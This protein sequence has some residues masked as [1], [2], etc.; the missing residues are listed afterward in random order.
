MRNV[1]KVLIVDDDKSS[2]TL[3]S[4]VVKRLGFK[5]IIAMK[6][7]D[8]LNVAKLQ[9][10]HAAIIDVLLPKIGGVD[11]ALEFRKTKFAENPIIF[12]SGVF[13]DKNFAT[14]SIRKTG[15]LEFLFKPFNAEELQTAL[16]NA[17]ASQMVTE[18]MTAQS[19]LVRRLDSTRDKA[20]AIEHLEQVR[21]LEFP[22]VLSI[23][24][25]AGLSGHL[26]IVND[27]GEI[28]GVT[29]SKGTIAEVD[30]TES[31][32]TGVLALIKNGFM[33]QEDFDAFQTEASKK[34]P[35]DRLVQ[36]GLVSPHA[37]AVAK[38]EQ[39]LHDFKSICASQTMQVNFVPQE[40]SETPPKHA[41]KMK[42]LLRIMAS[43]MDEFFPASYLAEFY[44]VVKA[45]PMHLARTPDQV[46]PIWES[47][48]FSPLTALRQAVEEGGTLETV[49][50]AHPKMIAQ[51][52]QCLH[53][54][55]LSRNVVFDD[56]QRTKSLNTMLERYQQLL[57]QISGKTPDKVFEYFGGGERPAPSA[58][59]R[60]WDQYQKSNSPDQLPKDATQELRD[61][62]QRCYDIFEGAKDVMADEQKRAALFESL[63]VEGHA[64]HK[65]SNEMAAQALE[66]LRKGQ[67]E[68]AI[69]IC[70]EAMAV[71]ST[72]LTFLIQTW[73]QVKGGVVTQKPQL[74]EL[75][76]KLDGMAPDDRKSTYWYMTMGLL[77]KA[78]LDVS[79]ISM[80]EKVI[81]MDSTFMEARR[82]LNSISQTNTR[83]VDILNGDISAV[84]SQLFRTKA[85]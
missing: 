11:L 62:C 33:T 58:V 76:K 18:K 80:F 66:L 82:E 29:F 50:A 68:K 48:L 35:L 34:L 42:E 60:M 53:Y 46:A 26:N 44:S 69:A 56:V 59:L 70:K 25:D 39:I 32:V 20:K 54:L 9:T 47:K 13:K 75:V 73:A 31:Q 65:K 7:T 81:E 23:L 61:L 36:E 55:V 8:G 5:P 49:L 85:K 78:L 71:Q 83:K 79:A 22:F 14:E 37:V 41:V 12:V 3:L 4:E 51:V 67:F 27:A 28:F 10:V 77:K 30:S 19:L 17:L 38:H 21:G 52:Y 72:S 6:A 74:L 63:K 1:I 64:R 43:A 84:V 16:S 15:A 40:D 2:A 24:L 57:D 45:S